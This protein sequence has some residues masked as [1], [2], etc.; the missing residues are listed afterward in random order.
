MIKACGGITTTNRHRLYML[1]CYYVLVKKGRHAY[2]PSQLAHRYD[3]IDTPR[4]REEEKETNAKTKRIRTLSTY[5]KQSS[6][7]L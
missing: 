6:R 4:E 5:G 7:P 2:I 3:Y 1:V